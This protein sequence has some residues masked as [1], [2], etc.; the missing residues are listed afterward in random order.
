[1][2]GT[3]RSKH[4]LCPGPESFTLP[5]WSDIVCSFGVPRDDSN[6]N[7]SEFNCHTGPLA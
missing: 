3:M 2:P 6:G 7:S 1:M 5:I 4:P